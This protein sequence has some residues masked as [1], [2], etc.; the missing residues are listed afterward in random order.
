MLFSI[1]MHLK[2]T[3]DVCCI[4]SLYMT[5]FT[6]LAAVLVGMEV[7]SRLVVFRLLFKLFMI[8]RFFAFSATVNKSTI[9]ESQ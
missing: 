6:W 7:G 2:Q 4:I 3:C 8:S 1:V 9:S 5:F